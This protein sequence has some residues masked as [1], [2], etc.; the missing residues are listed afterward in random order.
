MNRQATGGYEAKSLFVCR[1]GGGGG[2]GYVGCLGNTSVQIIITVTVSAHP[3]YN[4][5]GS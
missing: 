3:T 1:E 5:N 4:R 2:G